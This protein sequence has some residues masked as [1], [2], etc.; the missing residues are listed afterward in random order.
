MLELP[1][2]R[3]L[4]VEDHPLYRD[5][6]L[7]ML[8]RH[9]PKLQC[10]AVASAEA[11]LAQLRQHDDLDLVLA[12]HHLPG[13][14]DG[15][16]LL[17]AIGQHWPTAARVLV[18]GSSDPQLPQHARRLGLMGYLPKAMEP[19][20]WLRALARILAGEPWFPPRLDAATSPGITGRQAA[21]LE[22]VAAGR[23]NREIAVEFSITER[24]VKYHL[25]EVFARLQAANR[26]EALARASALGWIRL[27]AARA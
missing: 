15:L 21:I 22:R 13:A 19:L 16:A 7:G 17:E 6:L 10:Q 12:D 26:T 23:T 1:A 3:L 4:I 27:P 24:T 9:A 8:Q 18:S 20:Q 5:G 11:A 25:S 2:A 14:M